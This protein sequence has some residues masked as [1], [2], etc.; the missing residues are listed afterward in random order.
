M[1]VCCLCRKDGARNKRDFYVNCLDWIWE[2][3]VPMALIHERDAEAAFNGLLKLRLALRQKVPVRQAF[4]LLMNGILTNKLKKSSCPSRYNNS[5]LDPWRD[6][7]VCSY[8]RFDENNEVSA[9]TLMQVCFHSYSV[10]GLNFCLESDHGV[11]RRRSATLHLE[12]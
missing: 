7:I 2:F 6:I 12:Y 9:L 5:L 1:F 4:E 3:M 8:C 11:D 10:S